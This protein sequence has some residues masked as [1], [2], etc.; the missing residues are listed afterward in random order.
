MTTVAPTTAPP[1]SGKWMSNKGAGP[2]DFIEQ[3]NKWGYLNNPRWTIEP[4][5]PISYDGREDEEPQIWSPNDIRTSHP[6]LDRGHHPCGHWHKGTIPLSIPIGINIYGLFQVGEHIYGVYFDIESETLSLIA[7]YDSPSK[8]INGLVFYNDDLLTVAG[9]GSTAVLRVISSTPDSGHLPFISDTAPFNDYD[10]I[11]SPKGGLTKN[12][13]TGEFYY[14]EGNPISRIVKISDSLGRDLRGY[15]GK[16]FLGTD[17]NLYGFNTDYSAW[18]VIYHPV[19]GAS[20]ATLCGGITDNLS[21]VPLGTWGVGPTYSNKSSLQVHSIVYDGYLYALTTSSPNSF[22]RKYDLDTL[23]ILDESSFIN[24]AYS[25]VAFEGYIYVSYGAFACAVNKYNATTLTLIDTLALPNGVGAS[26]I[27]ASSKYLYK[28]NPPYT[29]DGYLW[30]IDPV[31]FTRIDYCNLGH[32]EF[33]KIALATDKYLV[34]GGGTTCA[35]VNLET[36]TLIDTITVGVVAHVY[37]TRDL[38]VKT[39]YETS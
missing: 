15:T 4:V 13:D 1:P 19:T 23:V 14:Q 7:H 10:I 28:L 27:I 11:N 20:W 36:M 5:D 25:L 35:V 2:W 3:P 17:G 22:L 26:D 9:N 12:E 21:D 32:H 31:T 30:K 39:I 37:N 6:K 33:Q 16:V 38:I 24:S 34:L 18:Q 29:G 8:D